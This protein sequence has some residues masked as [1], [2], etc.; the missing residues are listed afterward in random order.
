MRSRRQTKSLFRI[1]QQCQRFFFNREN[2]GRPEVRF[3]QLPVI[4]AI[5]AEVT[6]CGYDYKCL[7]PNTAVDCGSGT[8]PKV[9]GADL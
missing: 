4:R 7:V 6:R 8:A 2:R 3:I 9:T 5:S 1:I